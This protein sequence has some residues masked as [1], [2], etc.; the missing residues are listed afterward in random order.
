MLAVDHRLYHLDGPRALVHLDA[1]LGTPE[2]QAIQWV[3]G[4]GQS[5][6]AQWFPLLATV[7]R[8]GKSLL[9]YLRPGEL[10]LVL[11]ALRTH[12]LRPAGLALDIGC[13]DEDEAYACLAKV[14]RAFLPHHHQ[15]NRKQH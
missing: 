8:A 14:E 11:A 1:L 9:I 2:L 6:I 7:Q 15:G 4:A 10:D 3:P 12:E 13:A 5:E